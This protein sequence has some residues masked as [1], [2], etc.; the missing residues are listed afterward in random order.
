MTDKIPPPTQKIEPPWNATESKAKPVEKNGVKVDKTAKKEELWERNLISRVA[1]ASLQEQRRARRWGIFFK[2][3]MFIYLAI[4]LMIFALSGKFGGG[5]GISPG[6]HTALIEVRG[7]IADNAEASADNLITSLRSAFENE[8]TAGIILRINSPGGSPV[9]AGYISDEIYRLRELYPDIPVYAVITD[10]C[11]SGG[12]YIAAAADKIYADKASIV[13]SIGVLMDSFGFTGAME[14]LGVE[15]RLLT[16]G[17]NKGFMDPFSPARPEDKRHIEG[18]LNNIHQQFIDTVKK[19]RGDR[20]Q[21]GN[22]EL[23]S[24]L[25]WTGEKSI[26]LG[27]VDGLGSSS[28]VAR[29][30]IGVE[31]IEDFTRHPDYFEQ[32]AER[33]GVSIAEVLTETYSGFQ[34]K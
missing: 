15:R 1:L 16:A 11:A 26:E 2:S 10:M 34:L 27:L 9:Q 23:F 31:R 17:D 19:G 30:L 6:Q 32:L 20:L 33:I 3:L 21:E 25:V 8:N 24:G 13:G 29:E 14:K 5:G 18:L 12:Y 4:V 22:E 7:V 28:Y